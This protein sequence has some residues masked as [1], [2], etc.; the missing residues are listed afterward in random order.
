MKKLPSG[1]NKILVFFISLFLLTTIGVG[2][3]SPQK[4]DSVRENW[5][6]VLSEKI[7]IIKQTA[8][9]EFGRK[10]SSIRL[11]ESKMITRID[12]L[13][14]VDEIISSFSKLGKNENL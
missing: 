10:L 1:K 13:Q 14:N 5:D 3:Y 7:K 12:S 4:I 9:E 2:I 6:E 11:A 8:Q